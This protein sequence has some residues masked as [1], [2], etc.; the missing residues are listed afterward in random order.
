MPA[1]VVK[2][3][4][5]TY[6][7]RTGEPLRVLDRLSFNSNECQFVCI[8]GP[9]GCGKTT[10]LNVLAGLTDFEGE[11]SLGSDDSLESPVVGYVFQSPRLLPWKTAAE[12]IDFALRA[13]HV[14]QNERERRIKNYLGM[15]DL[16]DYANSFPYELSEGMRARIGLARAL[17]IGPKIFLMDEPFSHLDE[18]TARELRRQ[19]VSIWQKS[20]ATVIFVTHNPREAAFLADRI[21]LLS[22]KPARIKARLDVSISRP[23][24]PESPELLDVVREIYDLLDE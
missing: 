19:L 14:E 15:V 24:Q 7:Q 16:L 9:S 18:I 23:R 22:Q 5:K 3:L 4:T 10:L 8:L 21:F 1:V 11:V 6:E 13:H 17:S 20:K 12:N 2:D